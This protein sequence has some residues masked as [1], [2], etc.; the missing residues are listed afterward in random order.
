MPFKTGS[1]ALLILGGMLLFQLSVAS[2]GDFGAV[3]TLR[4]L[5][6]P[7]EYGN[8]LI[9]RISTRNGVKPVTF[10]HWLHR[11]KFTCRVCHT[12][13]EFNMKVNTTEITESGNRSGRYCGAC[14]NG[15][16]A[17]RA[18]GNCEKCH[19]GNI[20][21]SSEKFSE[22]QQ[23]PYPTTSFGNL[24][25]WVESLKRGMI[26]PATH[27]KRKPQDIPFNKTLILESEWSIISPAIFPHKAHV[28]WLDCS[29]CHPDIFN[30]KKKTTKHF[31]MDAILDGKFCGVCHLTVAFPI[32][33]CQGCHPAQKKEQKRW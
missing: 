5:P 7:E 10:S 18:N 15:R 14:H 4:P 20:A 24:V 1:I 9:D 23:K 6:P 26:N 21:Y 27:L 31:S 11:R 17:F 2:E 12:D 19:N 13:L 8:V 29:N 33:D 22:F 3:Y 32:N 16:I 30:I 28:E 25:N